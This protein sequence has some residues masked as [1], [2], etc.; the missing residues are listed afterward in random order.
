MPE[1]LTI[2]LAIERFLVYAKVEAGLMPKTIEEYGRDLRDLDVDLR[3]H[4]RVTIEELTPRDFAEHLIR[5]RDERELDSTTI[6]RHLASVRVFTKWLFSTG[7]TPAHHG[8][9]LERPRTWRKLPKV[10]TPGAM[11]RLLDKGPGRDIPVKRGPA[12][13]PRDKAILELLYA[14]GLRN[15][16]LVGLRHEDVNLTLAVVRVFGKGGKLRLV[17]FGEPAE[18]AIDEY[19]RTCRPALVREGVDHS[20]RLFLSNT[21][22]PLERTGLWHIVKRCAERAGVGDIYPHLIRHSFATHLLGGGADLR[23]VQEMLGH[24]DIGTTEIYTHV[25][26]TQLRDVIRTKH[27][28]G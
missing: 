22:R 7:L 23:V 15:S 6:V 28:R 9:L 20:G 12:L 13:W 8:E 10:L 17:P 5:L 21:G 25:D 16:E 4:G 11:R 19:V 3:A 2:P 14:S 27:P 1:T 18:D 26:R 24:A